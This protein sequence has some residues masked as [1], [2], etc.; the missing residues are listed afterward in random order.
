MDY[1]KYLR[2][3]TPKNKSYETIIGNRNC[4]FCGYFLV[5]T[6]EVPIKKISS[7]VSAC[8]MCYN[9]SNIGLNRNL[10][11]IAFSKLKQVDIVKKTHE[12]LALNNPRI[13]PKIS[14]IDPNA[15]IVP[16]NTIEFSFVIRY[17]IEKKITKSKFST[18]KVF[19]NKN[20]NYSDY[21]GKY[22]GKEKYLLFDVTSNLRTHVFNDQE[23]EFLKKCFYSINT[24]H[25]SDIVDMKHI[26]ENIQYELNT[27]PE[28][29]AFDKTK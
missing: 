24:P 5:N 7:N 22:M 29:L 18:L 8:Y 15:I 16:I 14:L 17:L 23:N 25:E 21:Y 13:I 12:L 27:F 9:I 3:H 10:F 1:S 2:P 28:L 26:I 20:F 11:V 19:F 6:Y 4:S